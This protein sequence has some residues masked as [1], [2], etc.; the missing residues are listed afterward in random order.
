MRSRNASECYT[1][2]FIITRGVARVVGEPR[3]LTPSPLGKATLVVTFDVAPE[4]LRSFHSLEDDSAGDNSIII[5]SDLVA[6]LGQK[7]KHP[8]NPKR[9]INVL[10]GA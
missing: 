5:S 2:L 4:I 3:P 6:S 10:K 1:I 9:A 8:T 7:K